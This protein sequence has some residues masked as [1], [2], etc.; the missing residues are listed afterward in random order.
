MGLVIGSPNVT[1]LSVYV[2]ASQKHVYGS[3]N[4]VT[5]CKFNYCFPGVWTD[6]ADISLVI[7]AR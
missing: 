3:S 5:F 7:R 4:H 6:A 2:Q 1:V